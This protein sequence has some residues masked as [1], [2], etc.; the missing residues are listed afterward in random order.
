ML[1]FASG[2]VVLSLSLIA[3]SA[4]AQPV[5]GRNV[6]MIVFG[7]DGSDA[8]SFR[9]SKVGEWVETAADHRAIRFRFKEMR[10][11]DW[12]VYLHDASRRVDIQLDLHTKK[13]MFSDAKDAQRRELALILDA[14]AK[15][16]GWLVTRV[17]FDGQPGGSFAQSGKEWVERARGSQ[18]PRF[19]FRETARDD[20]SV[21]LRDESRGVDLQLDL[22]TGNIYFSD[23]QTPRQVLYRIT[24]SS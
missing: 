20:W 12:S 4:A 15:T 2:T 18:Q 16:N 13:V 5:T 1:R 19:R 24:G 11:D 23:A 14:Y 9:L 17:E 7:T 6:N 21:Y 8:G 3:L 10:R 22:H